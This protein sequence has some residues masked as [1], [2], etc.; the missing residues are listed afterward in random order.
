M[1]LLDSSAWLVHLLGE[2]GVE[3]VNAL[4]DNPRQAIYISALSIPEI[5]SRLKSLHQETHWPEVWQTYQVLFTKT[6]PADETIARQAVTLKSVAPNRLPTIDGLIAATA[7]V[8]NLTLVH[9][10]PHFAHIP[11]NLLSQMRL[12]PK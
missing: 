11:F 4:F 3:E 1:F 12:P 9:R 5:Y 6:I 10:D 8:H 2:A 7:I